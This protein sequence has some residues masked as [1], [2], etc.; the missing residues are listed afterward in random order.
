MKKK[1]IDVSK[2]NGDIDFGKVKKSGID[3][4]IIRAG[5]GKSASQKDVYF[6]RNYK[7]AK[8]A[9][10]NVGTYWYSYADSIAAAKQEASVFLSVIKGKQFEYPVFLDLEEQKQFARGKAFCSDLVD[11]FCGA[12]E[13]AGYFAGLYISRSPLQNYIN[14]DVANRYALWIAE[15]AS[16]CKYGGT[17]GMWQYSS[18]GKVSGINGNCDMN[19]CYIDYPSII[20]NGGYNGYTPNSTTEPEKPEQEE[21]MTQEQFNQMIDVYL[22]ERAKLEP[23]S[24]SADDRQ[25][26][27][28]NGLIE[29]DPDGNKRYKSFITR[30]EV[31]VVLHRFYNLLK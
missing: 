26:A 1:G 17:Y 19:Y 5:Y 31:T 13:K 18:T 12:V 28:S 29:G 2:W 20:K 8:A 9:G 27:E 7:A 15:Y 6:E 16:K 4:V 23:G 25:W 30:E 3:F 10:L 22:A 14:A 24:W 11:A 21:E